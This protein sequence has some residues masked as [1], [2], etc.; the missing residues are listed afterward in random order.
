MSGRSPRSS[1]S[2]SKRNFVSFIAQ[3]QPHKQKR[4]VN[5]TCIDEKQT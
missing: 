3:Q 4:G 2:F 1:Q 5:A